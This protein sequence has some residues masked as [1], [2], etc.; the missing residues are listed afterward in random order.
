MRI[1]SGNQPIFWRSNFPGVP[2][3]TEL[4]VI[5]T[6][7]SPQIPLC[8]G[9]HDLAILRKVSAIHCIKAF[10]ALGWPR[11]RL[12]L[13]KRSTAIAL[14]RNEPGGTV[15]MMTKLKMIDKLASE[16]RDLYGHQA[17]HLRQLGKGS[18]PIC[19]Y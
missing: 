18:I 9:N 8:L 2:R 10:A 16:R 3:C 17:A 12:N 5:L 14:F 1:R 11:C 15:A 4:R 7:G 19:V 13:S 6:A